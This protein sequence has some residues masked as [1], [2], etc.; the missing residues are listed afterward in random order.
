MLQLKVTNGE[1]VKIR[2]W[3]EQSFEKEPDKLD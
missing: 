1:F 3:P 2:I